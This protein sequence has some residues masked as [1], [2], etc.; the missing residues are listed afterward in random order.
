[1]A[2]NLYKNFGKVVK[3]ATSSKTTK[4][5]STKSNSLTNTSLEKSIKKLPLISKLA[6]ALFFII[7]V[8]A[9]I[10]ACQFICKDDCFEINGRKSIS[11]VVGTEYV[12]DGVKVVGFG[13]DLSSKVQIVV[14]KD[15]EVIES[16]E[17]IDTSEEA[18]YQIKYTVD[19]FRFR[20]VKLV[21]TITVVPFEEV[22]PEED[23]IIE[24]TPGGEL[25]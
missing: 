13:Q 23:A 19:S 22:S 16:I 21:R 14:Y 11:I 10:F 18:T 25:E 2:N 1:M 20:G 8:V 7:G 15:G 3:K 6:I 9:S 17:D 24:E 5:S 12:D 4:T